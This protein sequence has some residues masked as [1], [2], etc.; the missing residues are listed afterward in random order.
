[1]RD[2]ILSGV[3]LEKMLLAV[4][5]GLQREHLDRLE[6]SE[7]EGALAIVADELDRRLK[8]ATG[9]LGRTPDLVL[10]RAAMSALSDSVDWARRY[11]KH[12]PL[13]ER[14][15]RI[16][17]GLQGAE[18][19]LNLLRRAGELDVGSEPALPGQADE[20]GGQRSVVRSR[21]DLRA[22]SPADELEPRDLP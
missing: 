11:R 6:L 9:H 5:H 17:G 19:A 1:M 2:S 14:R 4:E 10:A 16:A 15:E 8:Q 21:L 3:Q 13:R 18:G 7:L 20:S 12:A 22:Q